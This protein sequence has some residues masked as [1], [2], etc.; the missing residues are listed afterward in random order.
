MT[1]NQHKLS[2]FRR[3][4]LNKYVVTLVGFFIFLIF[5]DNHNLISRWE[6]SRKINSME[7]EIKFYQSEI[8]KNKANYYVFF[9]NFISSKLAFVIIFVIIQKKTNNKLQ[10]NCLF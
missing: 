4:I 2:L 6:T 8:D 7:K 10:S 1:T 3:I 5:F 9:L